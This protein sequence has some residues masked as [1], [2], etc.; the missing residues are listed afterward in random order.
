MLQDIND[1]KQLFG[2]KVVVFGGDFRQ[3]LPV[4]QKAR[5]QE[6]IDASIVKSYLWPLLTKISLTENMRARFDPHFSDF[7]LRVGDGKE[8]TI[9][10]DKIKIPTSMIIP[11]EEDNI[12][13]KALIDAVFPNLNDYFENIDTMTNRAILTPKNDYVDD[14]NILLIEQFPGDATTYYNFDETIDKNEQA[15]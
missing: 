5:K 9:D 4:V 15:I 11:Y 2:G 12:S 7:L 13:L 8:P 6:M 3:V 1:S 10:A 14:I